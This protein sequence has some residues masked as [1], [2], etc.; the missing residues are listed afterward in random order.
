ME[1]TMSN[2]FESS[3]IA[4]ERATVG[5]NGLSSKSCSKPQNSIR[6]LL[7][8]ANPSHRDALLH[9]LESVS[10]T[11]S[12]H[13]VRHRRVDQTRTYGIDANAPCSIFESRALGEP[14]YSVLGGVIDSTL[15]TSDK[16]PKRRAIDDGATPLLAHLLQ[17]KLHATP[18]TA[19]IDRHH[20]VVIFSGGISSLCEDILNA[21]IVVGRIE[22]PESRDSLMNHGLYLGVIS[23]VTMNSQRLMTLRLQFLGCRTHRLFVPVRQH[24]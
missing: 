16:T 13:L 3:R 22:P 7:G 10:L 15:G 18:Y 1:G 9:R 2:L 5:N 23:N 20:P 6:N 17:L 24:H 8:A 19:E 14:K 21:G 11:G 4:S 12:D